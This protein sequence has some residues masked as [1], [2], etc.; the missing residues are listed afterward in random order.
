MK[1]QLLRYLL[2]CLFVMGDP[3]CAGHGAEIGRLGVPLGKIVEIQAT[4]RAGEGEEYLL[5][6]T[7]IEGIALPSLG[8]M[9]FRVVPMASGHGLVADRATLAKVWRGRKIEEAE[10]NYVGKKFRL[11][12]EESNG[13]TSA[14]RGFGEELAKRS[15]RTSGLIVWQVLATNAEV[16]P[17]PRDPD[18]IRWSAEMTK[19]QLRDR[20][21]LQLVG[22][23]SNRSPKAVSGELKRLRPGPVRDAGIA[24][25]CRSIGA[26]DP[27]G[28][29][30]WAS[31][32]SGDKLRESVLE[33][34]ERTE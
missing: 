4:V 19:D 27:L 31:E 34:L 21:L 5:D 7:S 26:R 16:E 28:A 9:Q 25:F 17:A 10:K 14:V 1:A 29:K 12:V 20:D 8:R 30:R 33:D 6:L 13:F 22:S 11:L 32:I 18:Q 24:I 3:V 23:W 2:G 15:I